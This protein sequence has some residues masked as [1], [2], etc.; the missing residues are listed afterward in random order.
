MTAQRIDVIKARLQK[1]FAPTFLEVVDDSAKH[2]GHAGARGGA[3]HYTVIIAA[4]QLNEMPRVTAH[5]EIYHVL[6]DLMPHEI[7]ALQIQLLKK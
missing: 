5:R 7:H 3:G 2:A 1:K 6:D 4:A